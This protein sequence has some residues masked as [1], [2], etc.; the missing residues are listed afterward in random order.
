[1][2]LCFLGSWGVA[3]WLSPAPSMYLYLHLLTCVTL[4][5]FFFSE[6]CIHL[7]KYIYNPNIKHRK[8]CEKLP[9]EWSVVKV[10]RKVFFTKRCQYNY[11]CHYCNFYYYH[12]LRFWVVTI[13]FFLVLHNLSSWV[14]PQFTCFF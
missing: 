12:N 14:L 5:A 8:N 13:K 3:S 9:W 4:R 11:F 10:L 2:G 1:M 6:I 7:K